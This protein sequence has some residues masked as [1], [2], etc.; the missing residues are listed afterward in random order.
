MGVMHR[1]LR[2][3]YLKIVRQRGTPEQIALGVAVGVFVGVATPPFPF[4]HTFG[5]FAIAWLLRCSRTAAIV[6]IW[7]SNPITIPLFLPLQ[8]SIGRRVIGLPRTKMS[9]EAL[10]T[11]LRDIPAHRDVL[12]AWCI[13]ALITGVVA[14]VIAY[15]GVRYAIRVYRQQRE[16]HRQRRRDGAPGLAMDAST[17]TPGGRLR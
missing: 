10:M 11:F 2:F 13:G 15:V 16:E 12:L 6:G 7:V 3:W 14:T 9:I 4:L 17:E 8:M 5:A 1:S